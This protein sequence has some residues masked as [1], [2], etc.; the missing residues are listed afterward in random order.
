MMQLWQWASPRKLRHWAECAWL[1]RNNLQ[2]KVKDRQEKRTKDSLEE[3]SVW[4]YPVWV[5][6]GLDQ[7]CCW[8]GR[9][10]QVWR[11]FLW[12]MLLLLQDFIEEKGPVLPQGEKRGITWWDCCTEGITLHVPVPPVISSPCL[13]SSARAL[14]ASSPRAAFLEARQCELPWPSPCSSQLPETPILNLS[15]V[16][17]W[18]GKGGAGLQWQNLDSLF[19]GWYQPWF[20][21]GLATHQSY[22]IC[23]SQS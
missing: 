22:S 23:L 21:H 8:D 3:S 17:F 4:Y 16:S 20:S 11:G 7:E 19:A 5:V 2:G 9:R 10:L 1:Q 15:V 13:R 6:H 14:A 18:L 12:K